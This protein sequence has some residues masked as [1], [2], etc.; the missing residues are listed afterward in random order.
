V[1]WGL[2]L[3]GEAK[4]LSK[5]QKGFTLHLEPPMVAIGLGGDLEVKRDGCAR[6]K[7]GRYTPTVPSLKGLSKV[8]LVGGGSLLEIFNP[9][10][11]VPDI[12][13]EV[14]PLV[15]CDADVRPPC[16][17][18][19]GRADESQVGAIVYPTALKDT[20]P[21]YRQN[22]IWGHLCQCLRS[23]EAKPVRVTPEDRPKPRTR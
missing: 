17:F 9:D 2:Q 15:A 21:V 1:E 7:M 8:L 4:D 22:P 6:K 16:W 12:Q 14:G 23:I 20:V 10:C 18:L 19:K 5:V 11:K 3:L 13:V